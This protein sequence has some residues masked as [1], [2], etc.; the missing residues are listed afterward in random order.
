MYIFLLGSYLIFFFHSFSLIHPRRALTISM[1]FLL[2][3]LSCK[4]S[5]HL[6]RG[7]PPSRYPSHITYHITAGLCASSPTSATKRTGFTVRGAGWQAGRGFRDSLFLLW[8]DPHQDQAAHLLHSVQG[9]RSRPCLLF[10][11]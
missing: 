10:G 9:P 11:W 1:P 3:V 2:P 7:C 5:S 4:S 8:E 6:R